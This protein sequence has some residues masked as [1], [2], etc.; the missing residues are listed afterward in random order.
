MSKTTEKWIEQAKQKHGNKYDY[1][2][3]MYIDWKTKI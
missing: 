3:S 1:S 2:K